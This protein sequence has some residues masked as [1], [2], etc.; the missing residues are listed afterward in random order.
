MDRPQIIVPYRN[1]SK[2]INRLLRTL[3]PGWDVLIVNDQSDTSL[4]HL[5]YKGVEIVH[6]P[7][8][9][10]WAGACNF[11]ASLKPG[12]DLLFLNQDIHFRNHG[13]IA[14][15]SNIVHQ[16]VAITGNWVGENSRW[17]KGYVDG[18]FM[19][20]RRDAWD[21]A[22]GLDAVNYPM[23][24]GSCLLQAEICRRGFRAAPFEAL[25]KKWLVHHRDGNLGQSFRQLLREEVGTYR[26]DGN[27]YRRVP[28][29]VSVVIAAHGDYDK[30]LPD[31][32]ES[33]KQQT[34]RD[35]QIT[36]ALDGTAR[37]ELR[38]M[39][40]GYVDPWAG[41]RYV[42]LPDGRHGPPE[43]RNAG[44]KASNPMYYFLMLDGDD[45]AEPDAIEKMVAMA[46]AHP[47]HFVY[48][49]LQFE[50]DR[51]G[52]RRFPEYDYERLLKR[53]YITSFILCPIQAWRDL[54]GYPKFMSPGWDDY[55]FAIGIG[56]KG[57][58]GVRLAE[59]MLH[60]RRHG[61][62][63]NHTSQKRRPRLR[64]LLRDH[65]TDV[66][67]RRY[68]MGCCGSGKSRPRSASTRR[69]VGTTPPTGIGSAGMVEVRYTG[70]LGAS[71]SVRGPKT[72]TR[73]RVRGQGWVG[74]MDK[75]DALALVGD[76]KRRGLSRDY[77]YTGRH[78]GRAK[79]PSEPVVLV[80]EAKPKPEAEPVEREPEPDG[81][82]Q[83]EA[84]EFPCPIGDCGR[85]F[86][87][88]R[89]LTMHIRLSHSE[90]YDAWKSQR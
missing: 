80:Q 28:P 36:I 34:R 54:G 43:V 75:R 62:S 21:A 7:E 87:T 48:T 86:D 67:D 42:Q 5:K 84:N 55:G 30:Y 8:R 15:L 41:I 33:I 66:F 90:E 23:W 52:I 38:E 39:A 32:V 76:G 26:N 82:I 18:V 71:F 69:S 61:K 19:Y 25:R 79:P 72:G 40:E 65:Y 4:P 51:Q 6:L 78:D 45:W 53:N 57:W 70:G 60:Y 22:G 64:K 59:P 13:W 46:E 83:E 49:D 89:G 88:E 17:P 63:R 11:G 14:A 58:C 31:A 2:W 85:T 81:S 1:G 74:W 56:R 29:Y 73:Y 44:I 10:Y 35:W 3:P 27:I 12:R 24:G 9:G 20:V 47:G 77:E 37:P 50:G 16:D 68:P